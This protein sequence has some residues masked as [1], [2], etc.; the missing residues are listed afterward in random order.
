ME[1]IY[2]L[3][4]ERAILEGTDKATVLETAHS[5][6]DVIKA[7]SQGFLNGN[8]PW[9][10]YKVHGQTLQDETFLFAVNHARSL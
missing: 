8:S 9:Y 2:L 5:I 1:L 7:S 6:E 10:S 3:Y 4:D